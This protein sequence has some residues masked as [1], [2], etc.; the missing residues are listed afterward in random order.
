M[1]TRFAGNIYSMFLSGGNERDASAATDVDYVQSAP[2]LAGHFQCARDCF[3]LGV[4][5]TGIKVIASGGFALGD[6]FLGQSTSNRFAFG[7]DGYDF[8]QSSGALH[9]FTQSPI[10]S[11]R[12][13][14]DAAVG[15]KGFE[16][17]HATLTE[18]L[19]LIHISRH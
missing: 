4:N 12:K 2:G 6:F 3:Q 8:A 5:R 16:T 17:D 18:F 10:I 1:R 19:Q 15:H 14:L 11:S 13:I 7:M 9:P